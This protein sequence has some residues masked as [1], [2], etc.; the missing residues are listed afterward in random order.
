[1]LVTLKKST[2]D[3]MHA[4]ITPVLLVSSLL[5]PL[6]LF[7]LGGKLMATGT[8]VVNGKGTFGGGEETSELEGGGAGGVE[9]I[10]NGAGTMIEK[11]VTVTLKPASL[12]PD[13]AAAATACARLTA[14]DAVASSWTIACE[15]TLMDRRRRLAL[16]MVTILRREESIFRDFALLSSICACT[17]SVMS[18]TEI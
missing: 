6:S 1:M 7:S 13:A 3:A 12:A 10:S 17:F 9:M 18:D 8:F 16:V 14:A 2:D 11:D 4:A 5:V 15:L